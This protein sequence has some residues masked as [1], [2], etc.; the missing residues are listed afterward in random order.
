MSRQTLNTVANTFGVAFLISV[1]LQLFAL[2]MLVG[3]HDFAYDIHSKLFTLTP[4]QFD[5]ASY[6]FLGAMKVL[7]LSLFF[8]PW[9][10]CKIVAGRLPG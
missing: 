7:G 10:A 9:A 4:V 3:L 5:V 1:G 2:A 8:V 6:S